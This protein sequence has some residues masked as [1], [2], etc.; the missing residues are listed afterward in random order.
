MCS[1]ILSQKEDRRAVEGVGGITA[2]KSQDHYIFSPRPHDANP[3]T[4][5][6]RRERIFSNPHS[7]FIL[8][9]LGVGR[10]IYQ[11]NDG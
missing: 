8:G 1:K 3:L 6:T 10:E 11:S 4:K 2:K 7:L 9:F 5:I